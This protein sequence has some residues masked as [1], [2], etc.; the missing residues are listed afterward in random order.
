MTSFYTI[1]YTLSS[2]IIFLLLGIYWSKVGIYNLMVKTCCVI[3]A[4]V[5]IIVSLYLGGFVFK[6]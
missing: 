4:L 6:I 2:S 5:G 1:L 3:W